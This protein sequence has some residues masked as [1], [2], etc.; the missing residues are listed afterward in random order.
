MAALVR[1]RRRRDA[2]PL[3]GRRPP[4]SR[5]G[6]ARGHRDG[7]PHRCARPANE[8][9]RRP[10]GT[11]RFRGSRRYP[12]YV[13]RAARCARHGDAPPCGD[14]GRHLPLAGHHGRVRCGE[15]ARGVVLRGFGGRRV[16]SLRGVVVHS[17]SSRGHVLACL[18][19]LSRRCGVRHL[20]EGVRDAEK[21]LACIGC[22]GSPL[23]RR[24]AAGCRR[25]NPPH[26]EP[27]GVCDLN[28]HAGSWPRPLDS[29]W[30]WPGGG[31]RSQRALRDVRGRLAPDF[32]GG[33][34]RH[35]GCCHRGAWR[36]SHG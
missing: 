35:T 29:F 19:I 16:C 25:R 2:V 24:R 15:G 26:C 33:R 5:Q 13:V 21:H 30:L 34:H 10:R 3:R 28:G 23:R 11:C 4:C 36:L 14:R 27:R 9:R 20:S 8:G 18:E 32:R 12:G 17:N 22:A 6:C 31:A 1:S 7:G